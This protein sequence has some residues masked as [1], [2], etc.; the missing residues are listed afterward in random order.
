MTDQPAPARTKKK[1]LIWI[2]PVVVALIIAGVFIG[3]RIYAD[4]VSV[5]AEDVPKLTATPS[6]G[7]S[8]GAGSTGPA[9]T[10][11]DFAG[12]WAIGQG[13]YAGYRLNEVLNGSDVTV[14]GRTEDVGGSLTVE[15]NKLTAARL[16]LKVDTIAT[17]SDN[18]DT[19]FRTSA[20]DTSQHPE[21]TFTLSDPVALT[22]A[23]DGNTQTF[24]VTGN[25][26]INGQ[27]KSITANVQSAFSDGAAQLVGQIPVTWADFG[28]KAP[29]LGFVSV[30]DSG[31]IEFSLDVTQK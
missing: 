16:T 4:S 7:A 31:F 6:G 20:I 18:R 29:N 30:E 28:V 23:A 21:A 5:Q 19:Y 24:P 3:S 12:T 27:T 22:G 11:E 14:T 8:S 15:D 10:P 17:D 25:L 2:I 1:R 9:S 26:T 13:S